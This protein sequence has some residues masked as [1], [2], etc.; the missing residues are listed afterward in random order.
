MN[1]ANSET[2]ASFD[3]IE[4]NRE[5]EDILALINGEDQSAG[6]SLQD[7]MELEEYLITHDLDAETL[8]CVLLFAIKNSSLTSAWSE[9]VRIIC[10]KLNRK[11]RKQIIADQNGNLN[12]KGT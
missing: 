3:Q 4:K 7:T 2:M 8:S 6:P 10:E 9:I 5:I 1:V 12:I 11:K